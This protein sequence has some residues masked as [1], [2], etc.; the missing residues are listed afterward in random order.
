MDAPIE[1]TVALP[2]THGRG[3]K[4]CVDRHDDSMME[5][6]PNLMIMN[7]AAHPLR[8]SPDMRPEP[9]ARVSVSGTFDMPG[10][11]WTSASWP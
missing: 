1:T 6:S 9:A 5:F 2:A 11:P 7:R 8:I 4:H 10:R 3:L